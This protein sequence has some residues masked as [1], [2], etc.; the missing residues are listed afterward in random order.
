M[1]TGATHKSRS[2][3]ATDDDTLGNQTEAISTE[4]DAFLT[5]LPGA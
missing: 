4:K 2:L 3:N 5:L 1:F